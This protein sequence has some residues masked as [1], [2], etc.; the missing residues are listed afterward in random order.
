M[1][2]HRTLVEAVIA[3]L[4]RIFGE[5]VYADKAVEQVLKQNPKWGARDRRFIAETTYEMVRWWRLIGRVANVEAP[6]SDEE[7]WKLFAVWQL[8]AQRDLPDWQVFADIDKNKVEHD[9]HAAQTLRKYRES[10]PDWL[11]SLGSAELGDDAWTNELPSLNKEAAVVLR[12][13]TL[14]TSVNRLQRQLSEQS[15]ETLTD[16]NYPDA[17]ILQKRQSLQGVKEYKEGAFEVQDASSQL[18]APYMELSPGMSVIDACAGA[19]GKS[20]HIAALLENKGKIIS[21]D[22]EERKLQELERRAGRAGA[23]IIRTQQIS[24]Q[25]I[26]QLKN[27]ADRLLLD[28]PC[29]GLGVM[30]RNPDAKWKLNPEFINEIKQTQQQIISG[31]ASMLRPGGLLIYA[32]CSI[33]PS[34]N[35]L[36]VEKFLNDHRGFELIGDR[37][38]L[39]SEGFDGFYMA[40]MKKVADS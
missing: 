23:N 20:L 33:L 21:M 29:S 25:G 8:I 11:D 18:I 15:I 1:K 3:T 13:N 37:K 30:R 9:L 26:A 39:A 5:G 36:Q 16:K 12:A 31:Y 35:Q 34:E 4:R 2:F 28:V 7:Y 6:V 40:K 24:R 17:L 10:I 14:K 32:T 22:V 19:G 38:V 27:S